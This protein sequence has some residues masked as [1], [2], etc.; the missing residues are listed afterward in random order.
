MINDIS[1]FNSKDFNGIDKVVHGDS[2]VMIGLKRYSKI[3]II[4]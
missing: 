3:F 2:G 4:P 1:G